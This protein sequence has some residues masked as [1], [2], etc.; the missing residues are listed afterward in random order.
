M[1]EHG[2]PGGSLKGKKGDF[3]EAAVRAG[4]E[5][6]RATARLLA[7]AFRHSHDVHVFHDLHI[8]DRGSRT[9][10]GNIDHLVV[11]G[12]RVVVVDSKS[13]KPGFYWT[14]GGHTRRG[15]ESFPS[16]D[17]ATMGMAVDR[18]QSHLGDRADVSGLIVVHSSAAY[19]KPLVWLY[20]PAQGVPACSAAAAGR[21]LRSALG[22]RAEEDQELLRSVASLLL[23]PVRT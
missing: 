13:W 14:L 23:R 10:A 1:R 11:R 12:R 4:L 19:K 2:T 9:G 22:P 18:L 15:F 20:Q 21:R 3:G 7:E 16:A 17:K 6:E 8:P 5:G